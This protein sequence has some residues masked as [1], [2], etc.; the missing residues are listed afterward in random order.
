[1]TNLPNSN[2]DSVNP[3]PQPQTS[4]TNPQKSSL[5]PTAPP[6]G[7]A[8]LCCH[9]DKG[10]LLQ[11]ARATVFNP[12]QPDMKLEVRN[13][14]DSGSQ[15]SFISERAR[16]LL[17]LKSRDRRSLSIMA[18]G[19]RERKQLNCYSV[20]VGVQLKDGSDPRAMPPDNS[21]YL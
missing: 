9:S 5:N 18:F 16:D 14:L 8:G 11:T 2:P 21:S 15:K 20:K 17:N 19:C 6:F 13:L 7:A 4:S 1:M 3:S 12:C 10:V